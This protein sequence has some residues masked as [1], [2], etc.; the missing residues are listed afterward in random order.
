MF[1]LHFTDISMIIRQQTYLAG[2]VTLL[3][4]FGEQLHPLDHR[5]LLLGVDER[6]E[7]EGGA[8]LRG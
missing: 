8:E 4:L 7:Q 1:L 6:L 3:E 5:R 2:L